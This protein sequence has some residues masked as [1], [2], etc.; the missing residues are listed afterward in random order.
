M[1]AQFDTYYPNTTDV[2]Q[3]KDLFY[4][5][6]QELCEQYGNDSYAGH[7]GIKD[8]LTIEDTL[9]NTEQEALDWL[10]ENNNKWG[11]AHLVKYKGKV[12]KPYAKSKSTL[13]RLN[14]LRLELQTFDKTV[15]KGIRAAKSKTIGCKSC[16]SSISRS[17][18]HS[19][20]CPVC[21]QYD[22]FLTKTNKEKEA[23]LRKTI[24]ELQSRPVETREVDG[25]VLLIGGWC[26][27]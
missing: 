4:G 12:K 19:V 3:A 16:G 22:A 13:E 2:R 26:A 27:S 7:L 25:E 8:G 20:E 24:R 6:Q 10:H 17:H 15:V 21:G 11:S 9:F 5:R 1:G 23:R 18:L 14:R